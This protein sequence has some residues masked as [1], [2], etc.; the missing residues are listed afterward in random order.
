MSDLEEKLKALEHVLAEFD[1]IKAKADMVMEI[2]KLKAEIETEK[3]KLVACQIVQCN[4]ERS[5]DHYKLP[6]DSPY[7]SS[8]YS[9]C[10]KV[11]KREMRLRS[12]LTIAFETIR[13]LSEALT[14]VMSDIA[15]HEYT[16]PKED[17]IEHFNKLKAVDALSKVKERWG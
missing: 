8:T 3:M 12:D 13:E 9:E 11:V 5:F 6:N 17:P 4:T 15:E 7:Y 1:K 10:I 14:A 16:F 2:K